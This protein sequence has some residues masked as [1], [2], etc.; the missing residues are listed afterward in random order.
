MKNKLFVRVESASGEGAYSFEFIQ[1]VF[2]FH[3]SPYDDSLSFYN[4]FLRI[5]D[6]ALFGFKSFKAFE[7][8]FRSDLLDS[9]IEG[10]T[11]DFELFVSVYK[12]SNRVDGR[13]QS[14]TDASKQ[15]KLI[16]QTP[17]FEYYQRKELDAALNNL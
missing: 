14:V 9:C 10:E 13:M 8:W 6:E 3:P 17:L 4:S 12:V 16:K 7:Q 1:N 11:I 15:M 2:S 5:K